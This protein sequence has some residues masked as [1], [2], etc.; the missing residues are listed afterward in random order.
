MGCLGEELQ[1]RTSPCKHSS[2]RTRCVHVMRKKGLEIAASVTEVTNSLE[3]ILQDA[4]NLE[5]RVL[6]QSR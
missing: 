6:T 5:A 2:Q 4:L 1:L 3:S